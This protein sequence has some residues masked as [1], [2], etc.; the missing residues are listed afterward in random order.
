M[1]K[2]CIYVIGLGISHKTIINI[3]YRTFHGFNDPAIGSGQSERVTIQLLQLCHQLLIDQST[4][5]H[6]HEIDRSRIGDSSAINIL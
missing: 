4:V 3:F 1:N 6:C 5:N 2:L